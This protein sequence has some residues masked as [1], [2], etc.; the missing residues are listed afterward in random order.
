MEPQALETALKFGKELGVPLLILAVFAY[1]VVYKIF[2]AF[3]ARDKEKD[4]ANREERKTFIEELRNITEKSNSITKNFEASIS[5]HKETLVLM[6]DQNKD[7]ISQVSK[8]HKDLTETIKTDL[9]D[10]KRSLIEKIDSMLKDL[11]PKTEK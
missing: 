6:K 8:S 9:L 5:L 4:E 1:F 7:I 2:P 3:L 10:V 11:S